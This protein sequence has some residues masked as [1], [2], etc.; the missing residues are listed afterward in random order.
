MAALK[1]RANRPV[2]LLGHSP[3]H[4]ASILRWLSYANSELHSTART[5]FRPL[6]GIDP[7]PSS[8]AVI[9]A[10]AIKT[11][12]VLQVLED[13]LSTPVDPCES[14][15][16]Q[17]QSPEA[18]SH[19]TSTARWYLVSGEITL[20]DYFVAAIVSRLFEYVLGV[21]ERKVVPNVVQ[22]WYWIV[23]SKEWT[24]VMGEMYV[25]ERGMEN[26]PPA[27][28]AGWEVGSKRR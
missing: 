3:K 26:K 11:K 16:A 9:D 19:N 25:C 12:Q 14:N 6:L 23:K 18:A 22:W 28:P 24:D 8:P 15:N 2:A 1:E 4:L 20:A 7:Y 21:E 5:W 27:A 10:A 17:Q 13:H